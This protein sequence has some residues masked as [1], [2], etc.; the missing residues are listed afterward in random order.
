MDAVYDTLRHAAIW[1]RHMLDLIGATLI[2]AYIGRLLW[3]VGEVQRGRRRFFSTHLL[4][5]VVTAIG[6]GLVADGVVE[7]VGLTGGAKTA[8]VVAIAYLG[9]RGLEALIGR[10]LDNRRGGP[11]S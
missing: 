3:H 7:H 4:W 11:P 1:I 5:E 10:L 2:L 6:V 9:P 8:A